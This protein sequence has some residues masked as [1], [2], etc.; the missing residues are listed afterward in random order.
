MSDMHVI[1]SGDK[2]E[3]SKATLMNIPCPFF[4]GLISQCL[5]MAVLTTQQCLTTRGRLC[6]LTS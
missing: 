6:T 3:A 4:F 5:A 2:L 1:Q